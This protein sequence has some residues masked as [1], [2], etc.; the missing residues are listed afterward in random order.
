MD[1]DLEKAFNILEIDP[2][3]HFTLT[4]DDLKKK[5]SQTRIKK[6]SR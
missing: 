6:S 1:L 5:I 4:L 2:K 3:D